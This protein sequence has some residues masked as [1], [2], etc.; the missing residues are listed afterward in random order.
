MKNFK[1][2]YKTAFLC[3]ALILLLQSLIVYGQQKATFNESYVQVSRENPS[4]FCLSNGDAY[5]AIGLNICWQRDSMDDFERW[6]RLLSENGGNFARIWAGHDTFDYETVYGQV[7]ESQIAKVD[8]VLELAGQYGI[9]VK[10]CM[11]NFRVIAPEAGRNHKV[12]YHVDNEGQFTS[13]EDYMS[14]NRGQKVFLDRA[15]FFKNRYG[16]DPRVFAWELWDEMNAI[17]I[18]PENK[19]RLLTPWNA[20]VL[21]EMQ[22]IFPK[23]FGNSKHGLFGLVKFLP[24]LCWRYADS[25]K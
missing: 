13:M 11:E 21:S 18:S 2:N 25:R 8:R 16:D 20:A 4:Y 6:F 12:S 3:A 10:M 7:N 1:T 17:W 5:L 22:K 19:D 15:W 24:A 14:D 9:K 23:K